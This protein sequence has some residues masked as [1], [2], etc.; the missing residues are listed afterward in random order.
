M[1]TLYFDQFEFDT[2]ASEETLRIAIAAK[3]Q[4]PSEAEFLSA[5]PRRQQRIGAATNS[6]IPFPSFQGAAIVLENFRLFGVANSLGEALVAVIH[7]EWCDLEILI[8]T[9]SVRIWY[10]WDTTA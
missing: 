5:C 3:P 4:F 8:E 7:E 2:P 1:R 10:H 9:P 6:R